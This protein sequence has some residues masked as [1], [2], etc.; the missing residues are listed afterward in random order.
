MF[1]LGN[2]FGG[3]RRSAPIE[4]SQKE[5]AATV[6]AAQL[7]LEHATKAYQVKVDE[8]TD[9][10][11]RL[12]ELDPI[13]GRKLAD[14]EN[15]DMDLLERQTTL[16]RIHQLQA[17]ISVLLERKTSAEVVLEQA[18]RQQTEDALNAAE[19][20]LFALGGGGCKNPHGS[21]TV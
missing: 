5:S 10:H 9:A 16:A 8:L 11:T 2:K 13:I 14:N 1:G 12:A 15:A 6:P 7:A 19:A 17:T 21:E 18:L 20:R 4:T 3:A